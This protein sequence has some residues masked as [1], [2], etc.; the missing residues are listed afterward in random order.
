MTLVFSKMGFALLMQ[1]LAAALLLV[2]VNADVER[3]E[4]FRMDGVRLIATRAFAA[5]AAI[6]K[7]PWRSI[8]SKDSAQETSWLLKYLDPEDGVLP[9]GL[10]HWVMQAD[11]V[12][13]AL[14]LSA[15]EQES[16]EWRS[17]LARAEAGL[18]GTALWSSEQRAWLEGSYCLQFTNEHAGRLAKKLA[19]VYE[20]LAAHDSATFSDAVSSHGSTHVSLGRL[21][22]L[23][24]VVA[25]HALVPSGMGRPVL[26]PL[27]LLRL[28]HGGLARLTV[29]HDGEGG[30][31][32]DGGGEGEGGVELRA[33]RPIS[34]GAELTIDALGY[35]VAA[36]MARQGDPGV[37]PRSCAVPPT[38]GTG[39]NGAAVTLPITLSLDLH[40]S[41][42]PFK[43]ALLAKASLKAEG[44]AF[45]LRLSHAT[46]L[47]APPS[48][49]LAYARLAVLEPHDRPLLPPDEAMP[50]APLSASNEEH[51]FR[52][53][54]ASLEAK[55]AG[56][57]SAVEEDEFEL[58]SHA[59]RGAGGG[60]GGA[61]AR[62]RSGS[63]GG[64]S[65]IDGSR[66]RRLAAVATVL[67]EKRL[68]AATLG[69]LQDDLL[70]F[71]A[72]E[73]V[74]PPVL[75]PPRSK[76]K[77]KR[78]KKVRGDAKSEL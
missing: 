63:R 18:N 70:A 41:L 24:D 36:L 3:I 44:H 31:G 39:C 69:Q 40:D 74:E 6:T 14:Q 43:R 51:A 52:L 73:P 38:F 68:L 47:P 67:L 2:V 32:E 8:L 26:L 28:E 54:A 76:K 19:S 33:V 30:G 45:V 1:L 34:V 66:E 16:S 27:P 77:R 12:V 60:G 7:V 58:S 10:P 59:A 22:H 71:Q 50:L 65:G 35:D 5:G 64:G 46:G 61:R 78:N 49:L 23:L 42:A 57:A 21:R 4:G 37:D 20:P 25:A 11:E 29:S 56:Y 17:W 15:L 9:P 62:G 53:I 13:I 48:S 75:P 72:G 55:L